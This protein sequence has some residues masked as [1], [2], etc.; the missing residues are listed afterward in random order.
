MLDRGTPDPSLNQQCASDNQCCQPTP[1]SSGQQGTPNAPE[2]TP[3]L[4]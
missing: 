1:R 3:R 4:C 2:Q